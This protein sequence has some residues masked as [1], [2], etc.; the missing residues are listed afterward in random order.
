MEYFWAVDRKRRKIL[1]SVSGLLP[2][3]Y[4]GLLLGK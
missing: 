1:E 2:F 4:Q 3:L